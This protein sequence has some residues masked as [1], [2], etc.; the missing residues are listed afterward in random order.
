MVKAA[1]RMGTGAGGTR[2]IAGTNHSLVTLERELSDLHGKEAALLF[3]PAMSQT[4][5]EFPPL[6][7]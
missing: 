5:R 3:T 4:K 7:D 6:L 2:N 1:L